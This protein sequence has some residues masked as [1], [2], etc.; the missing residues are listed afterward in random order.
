MSGA[1]FT[2]ANQETKLRWLF[3]QEWRTG[4][5]P[6]VCLLAQWGHRPLVCLPGSEVMDPLAC[7]STVRSCT[8]E[9]ILPPQLFWISKIPSNILNPIFIATGKFSYYSPLKAKNLFL[10]Q[11][12][13]ITGKHSWTQSRDLWVVGNPA[14]MGPFTSRILHL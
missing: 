7:S 12:E 11:I 4:T 6:L 8:W 2:Q 10:Q 1:K 9:K 3:P 13:A 5:R 14:A